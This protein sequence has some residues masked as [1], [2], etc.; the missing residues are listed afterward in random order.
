[1]STHHNHAVT[2]SLTDVERQRRL[3]TE[4]LERR[5]GKGITWIS[6]GDITDFYKGDVHILKANANQ[7]HYSASCGYFPPLLEINDPPGEGFSANAGMKGTDALAAS[8]PLPGPMKKRIA[9][10][11]GFCSGKTTVAEH[12]GRRYGFTT[13]GFAAPLYELADIH[14]AKA[15]SHKEVHTRLSSWIA[16]YLSDWT[17]ASRGGFYGD[18]MG[19]F[20]TNPI[21]EG[22]D[23]SLLQLLGT[24]V[25]RS[26]DPDLWTKL[27]EKEVSG[28]ESLIANDNLRFPN[29]LD[30]C[31]RMNFTVVYLDAPLEL[32]VQRYKQKYGEEPTMDQ[33][34]HQSE[35]YLD[36]MQREAHHV[37]DTNT[38]FQGTVERAINRIVENRAA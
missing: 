6:S 34:Q 8:G 3:V 16:R 7:L 15:Q 14:K 19:L 29:E 38:I 36:L 1:M 37:V 22:K 4:M 17:E 10:A 21:K 31:K 24:E 25:G 12:L 32:R 13:F 27:W 23:R 20:N 35:G 18:V 11:G 28:S 33:L 9:L 5:C 30:S 26:Y 2:S